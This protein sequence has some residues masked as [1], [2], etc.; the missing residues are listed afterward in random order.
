MHDI[1]TFNNNLETRIVCDDLAMNLAMQ[2][3]LECVLN[4]LKIDLPQIG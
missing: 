3:E 2:D 1:F 4:E